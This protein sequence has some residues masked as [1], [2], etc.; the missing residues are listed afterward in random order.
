[1][2]VTAGLNLATDPGTL[3]L[4]GYLRVLETAGELERVRHPVDVRELGKLIEASDRALLFESITGFSMPVLANAMGNRRRWALAFGC[5]EP[6][7]RKELEARTR[8]LIRP[9]RV[10]T[11]PVTEVI[12]V[13]PEADLGALPVYL[14]HE[15][16]GAPYFS[17]ALDVSKHPESGRYNTGVRR[18]MVRGPRQTGIDMVAPSDLRAAYRR[19]RE[20]GRKFEVAFVI[21]AHP[22]DYLATQMKVPCDDEF[23]I[24]GGLRGQ[25]VRLI[26]CATVDL[27]VPA[28]AELVLE[29]Y[30]EG[31]WTEVEGPFGEYTGCYGSSHLNPVFH[32]TGIMRR[33]DAILQSATI[34]GRRLD[35]T[36]TAVITALRTEMLIWESVSRAVAEP[37]QVYCP[38]AATGLHHVRISIHSRDP[39]DGRN[40]LVAA[41]ASNAEVKM[42]IVVDEDIDIFDDHAVEWALATRF[43]GDRD[44]VVLS[45][46]RTFP[47]DPS[48]PLHEGSR[49]TTAKVGFDCTRSYDRP[50]RVFAIPQPPFAAER[51]GSV[52]EPVVDDLEAL[53]ERLRASLVDG[54]HFVDWLDKERTVHQSQIIRALGI[55]RE[56]GLVSMDRE[57]RYWPADSSADRAATDT[58]AHAAKSES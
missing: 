40:A 17:A 13:G 10:D 43:Q 58:E 34:G 3:D 49:V 48:L 22:L 8:Q 5:D 56:R 26:R 9:I 4:R 52:P 24:M 47:L 41:L 44:L 38:T 31:D 32:L 57:G 54:P 2:N 29:G 12:L 14:Q 28:D 21:G 6:F 55:L 16:D 19:A 36:D 42:A 45:G 30:L 1:M 25:P 39:G 15:F 20:L 46:M 11:G 35:H 53:V 18:L 51:P 33:R 50:A 37:L 7:L 23:E 27:E